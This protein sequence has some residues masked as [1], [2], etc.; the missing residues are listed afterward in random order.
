M[1][2]QFSLIQP[3]SALNLLRQLATGPASWFTD[4]V[5]GAEEIWMDDP[6]LS[7]D[8]DLAVVG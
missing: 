2:S 8:D 3:R 6:F 5:D 1:P 7:D 4:F